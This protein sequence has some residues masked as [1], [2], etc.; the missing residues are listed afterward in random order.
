[1][2][3]P[4]SLIMII[5]RVNYKN[6]SFA[7]KK[8]FGFSC[9]IVST[10]S[11]WGLLM[12][13]TLAM[14]YKSKNFLLQVS[15]WIRLFL[16]QMAL[17]GELLFPFFLIC[18]IIIFFS[19][20]LHWNS[21]K[22]EALEFMHCKASDWLLVYLPILIFYGETLWSHDIWLETSILQEC[23]FFFYFKKS[24]IKKKMLY[25]WNMSYVHKLAGCI[26]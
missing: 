20:L 26:L 2:F 19:F 22:W 3:W 12:N 10:F 8:H 4:L 6:P 7:S 21:C 9:S 1:M 16:K 25:L 23:I 18:Y 5:D 24:K 17:F 14:D 11:P 13:Q 15:F